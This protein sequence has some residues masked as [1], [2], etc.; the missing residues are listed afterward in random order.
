MVRAIALYLISVRK[1]KILPSLS[2]SQ[3]ERSSY[4]IFINLF[5]PLSPWE[6]VR[7]RAVFPN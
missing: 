1:F 4:I 6:R 2:L 3:R 7:V 5:Y